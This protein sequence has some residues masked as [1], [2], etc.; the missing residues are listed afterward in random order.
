MRPFTKRNAMRPLKSPSI[1]EAPNRGLDRAA[2][3]MSGLCLVHCLAI[4]FALLLGPIASQ[5]L[6]SSET[7]V[8]WILLALALPISLVALWRGFRRHRSQ[9]TFVLGML[10]LLLMFIGVSHLLGESWEIA[11]TVIGVTALLIAHVRNM[12]GGHSHA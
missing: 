8:H 3:V 7:Q 4:P 10:G 2:V 5:W 6:T 11:L 12:L 1:D 9:F